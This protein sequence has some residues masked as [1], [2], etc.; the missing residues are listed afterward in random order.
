MLVNLFFAS[1]GCVELYICHGPTRLSLH[2][3]HW[4]A[5]PGGSLLR[6]LCERYWY[7]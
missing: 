6:V 1:I 4:F 5:G 7:V 3:W 2:L